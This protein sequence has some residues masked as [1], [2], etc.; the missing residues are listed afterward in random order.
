VSRKQADAKAMAEFRR[1]DDSPMSDF[2]LFVQEV[3]RK[4][5]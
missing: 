2:D 3:E 1:F 5:R 4:A